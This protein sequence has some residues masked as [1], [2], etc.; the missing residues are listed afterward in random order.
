MYVAIYIYV[1]SNI[2]FIKIQN[3]N[4]KFNVFMCNYYSMIVK[5]STLRVW[6]QEILIKIS[7]LNL[8]LEAL[9]FEFIIKNLMT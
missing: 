7:K 6:C 8:L 3:K 1:F 4:C 2:N 9:N 5:K